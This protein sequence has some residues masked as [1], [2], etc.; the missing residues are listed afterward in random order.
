MSDS[1]DSEPSV[2]NAIFL[3]ILLLI[4]GL[5]FATIN[6]AEASS[7]ITIKSLP[8]AGGTGLPYVW[9]SNTWINEC[10]LCGA[11]GTLQ[12]N[13]KGTYEKELTCK[14]CDADYCGSSGR[15][16]SYNCRATLTKAKSINVIVPVWVPKRSSINLTNEG[17]IYCETMI[18]GNKKVKTLKKKYLVNAMV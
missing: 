12:I 4:I 8:S 13:P 14:R 3:L 5:A 15:D 16:K 2:K 18:K 9:T 17:I 10:V 11:T 7:T 1:G 6:T